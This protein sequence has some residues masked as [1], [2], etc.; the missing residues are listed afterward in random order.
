MQRGM[1]AVI[2]PTFFHSKPRDNSSS[3]GSCIRETRADK[4]VRKH[5]RQS[6]HLMDE[7]GQVT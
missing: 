6:S 5:L 3:T 1:H 4:I 7:S 2:L